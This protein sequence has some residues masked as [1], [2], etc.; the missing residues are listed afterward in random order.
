M[1]GPSATDAK[2]RA[3]LKAKAKGAVK[4]LYDAMDG[5]GTDESAIFRALYT[6][7]RALNRQIQVDFYRYTDGESLEEWLRDELGGFDL[8][9]ALHLMR[10]GEPKL[11][12]KIVQ[13]CTGMGTDEKALIRHFKRVQT[14]ETDTRPGKQAK[15]KDAKE[16]REAVGRNEDGS[17]SYFK[18]DTSGGFR[19]WGLDVVFGRSTNLADELDVHCAG[20]GTDEKGIFDTVKSWASNAKNKGKGRAIALDS[21]HRV[22][23]LLRSELS[24]EEYL[25]AKEILIRDGKVGVWRELKLAAEGWGTDEASIYQALEGMTEA[26]K[27]TLVKDAGN[28]Q[29]VMDLLKSELGDRDFTK[30][31]LLF[32]TTFVNGKEYDKLL[33][34]VQSLG[35]AQM[36]NLLKTARSEADNTK[37]IEGLRDHAIQT[38]WGKDL[39]EV[40]NTLA[41]AI[42][43]KRLLDAKSEVL[44]ALAGWGTNK[45]GVYKALASIDEGTRQKL[46]KDPELLRPLRKNLPVDW[47]VLALGMLSADLYRRTS[48]SMQ[49]G[50]KG[51]GTD[52]DHLFKTLERVPLKERPGIFARLD[53]EL[54]AQLRAE[55]NLPMFKAIDAALKNPKDASKLG[56][57]VRLRVATSMRAGTD[58]EAIKD[59]LGGLKGRDL[60]KFTTWDQVKRKDKASEGAHLQMDPKKK[61]LIKSELS[62]GDLWTNLDAFRAKLNADGDALAIMK[63]ELLAR[64]TAAPQ[65]EKVPA[66]VG[67]TRE[68][69][70]KESAQNFYNII[71]ACGDHSQ[72]KEAV[73]H[74]RSGAFSSGIMDAF[75]NSGYELEDDMTAYD[76][77]L[78][79]A[80]G[81]EK[82]SDTERKDVEGAKKE[83]KAR[84][85][86]Y[87][88]AK[89][90][91][92]SIASTIVAVI[93]GAIVTVFTAGAGSGLA[94]M[95]ISAALAAGAG[96]A[97]GAIA[98]WAVMGDSMDWEAAG[99][100]IATAVLIGALTGVMQKVVNGLTAGSKILN[101]Q[102][103]MK[104]FN[105]AQKLTWG[106]FAGKIAV[107]NVQ[108]QVEHLITSIPKAVLGELIN[109]PENFRKILLDPMEKFVA[110]QVERMGRDALVNLAQTT[111]GTLKGG[112]DQKAGVKD[113]TTRQT[114]TRSVN[115]AVTNSGI[116]IIV[117]ED[118]I[119]KGEVDPMV[120]AKALIRAGGSGMNA[121]AKI[122]GEHMRR[123]RIQRVLT[124]SGVQLTHDQMEAYL[125][126]QAAYFHKPP[127]PKVW[128]KS[129]YP[130]V[131]EAIR[132][133]RL[134]QTELD[135]D[136]HKMMVDRYGEEGA[137]E[138]GGKK[139]A[140]EDKER[141]LA[142]YKAHDDAIIAA[143]D[144]EATTRRLGGDMESIK[145]NL[146]DAQRHLRQSQ[147]R[148]DVVFIAHARERLS[149]VEAQLLSTQRKYQR[150]MTKLQ[151]NQTII[152]SKERTARLHDEQKT[153]RDAETALIAARRQLKIAK[154]K[155]E[156]AGEE[157]AAS[158]QDLAKIS[159]NHALNAWEQAN[160]Q[161]DYAEE[162]FANAKANVVGSKE[163]GR[164]ARVGV[165]TR[166]AR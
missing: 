22:M 27:A 138:F 112:R 47:Y 37:K 5:I 110:P 113:P 122:K 29:T 85:A 121:Y 96:S 153:R 51:A 64:F 130:K 44:V 142:R 114:V 151:E 126:D 50:M 65:Q 2:A 20:W 54:T 165:S 128:L 139:S 99:I 93:V 10:W 74:E 33:A 92:A 132:K 66:P 43:G 100:E 115:S 9:K 160:H 63:D 109:D 13:A 26:E 62:S 30:T 119:R 88:A 84:L 131:K 94:A 86:E 60:L 145:K 98:K 157:I 152:A 68:V 141:W 87:K 8:K 105:E 6:G 14:A 106:Q 42:P 162:L 41:L 53:K 67:G 117:D 31:K 25:K 82:L 1:A 125:A 35:D 38:L 72:V 123:N 23:R 91:I 116:E 136:Y 148:R 166:V 57:D 11:S 97:A 69:P 21:K 7:D 124:D 16:Q 48:S 135:R 80:L 12:L 149:K 164:A 77:T 24:G 55:L 159:L 104:Q 101:V 144:A 150:A 70:P 163:R 59:I 73:E 81:D 45:E 75:S 32:D 36:L 146:Q 107:T 147:Q 4:V 15:A 140:I 161:R 3:N 103:F 78:A 137:R 155:A 133:E 61:R 39:S 79:K 156:Q 154:Y 83:A 90:K 18:G 40:L 127:D 129:R 118:F 19:R 108:A 76:L 143:A 111:L 56:V 158:E 46:C 58:E 71:K 52:E 17:L 95:M 49:A 134:K 28:V 102:T 120:I 89:D 34:K